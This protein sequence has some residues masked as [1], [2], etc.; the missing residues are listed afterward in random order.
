METRPFSLIKNS[1]R[2][3][4]IPHIKLDSNNNKMEEAVERPQHKHE[5]RHSYF[6]GPAPNQKKVLKVV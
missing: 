6:I 2:K 5:S 1:P 4:E 3:V